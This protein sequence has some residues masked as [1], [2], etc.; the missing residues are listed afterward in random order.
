[1][2]K[3]SRPL[4]AAWTLQ[5]VSIPTAVYLSYHSACSASC[6][7]ST[8]FFPS[9]FPW[10][11]YYGSS[12]VSIA[13]LVYHLFLLST[14]KARAISFVANGVLGFG[15]FVAEFCLYLSFGHWHK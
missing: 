12:A 10:F 9:D 5:L 14:W 2:P 6:Q 1:M 15:A 8:Q 4:L 13:L 3:P 11:F 7:R